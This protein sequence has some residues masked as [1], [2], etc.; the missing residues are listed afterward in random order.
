MR[1]GGVVSHAT[2]GVWGLACD[3]TNETAIKR[4]LTLKQRAP[5][6][7][8]I[9]VAAEPEAVAARVAANAADAWSRATAT[10]PGHTTWLLPAANHNGFYLTGG[11]DRIALRITAHPLCRALARASGGA[12]VSTSA[13][14]AG[15][16]APVSSW[17]V[18]RYFGQRLDYILGGHCS[19]PGQPSTIRDALSGTT[20]RP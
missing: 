14:P 8:L 10:W 20:A 11:G 5:T 13:N 9:I 7:G 1:A 17:R 15:R 3:P 2:E 4:I 19:H 16:P 18:R 12:I 6:R